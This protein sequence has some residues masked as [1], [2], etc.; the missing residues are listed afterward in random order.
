[1]YICRKLNLMVKNYFFF[2]FVFLGLTTAHSQNL[3]RVKGKIIDVETREVLPF[4]NVLVLGTNIGVISDENGEFVIKDVP[5]GYIKLQASFMG[6][7]TLISDDYLVTIEKT[8]YVLF[9]M[10]VDNEL[11]DEVVI[12]NKLFR[13]SIQ[14]PVSYQSIGIAEIEKNPGGD[15]DVLKVIQSFPGVASNPGFR[16]DIIIRGGSPSEN[17][18]YLDGIE[19]PVINHFQTQGSTGGPVGI[20]NADLIR[21]VDFY[22]SSFSANRGNALSSI[23]EFTMKEGD[24]VKVN[25]RATV[26]T[27]DAGVT[28]DGPMGKKTT[29]MASARQSYLSSL[30]K[31]LKLPFLPTYNDFQ[32]NVKHKFDEKNE[33]SLIGLGAID[34]FKLNKEV[35]DG[36]TDE[37]D[38]KRNNYFLSNIPV[39]NQW[40]YT[41][42]LSYKHYGEMGVQQVVLSRNQWDNVADKYENN[43]G[44]PA[45]LLLNYT[46]RETENKLRYEYFSTLKKNYKL[47]IGVGVEDIQYYNSTYQKFADESGIEVVDFTSKLALFKYGMFA[48]ISKAYFKSKFNVSFG[49]RF[50]GVDYSKEMSNPFKQFSPRFS[51]AYAFAQKWA[52]NASA[53]IYNQ[54]PSYTT[55][56]FRNNNEVLINKE[57]GLEYITANHLVTGF[58]FKPNASAKLTIEAFYKGYDNYPFSVENKISLANL[59]ADFGVVGNEEVTSTSEGRAY[60]FEVF[61]QKKSYTGL[62]GI[63]SY[64]YVISEFK[65]NN[66]QYIPSS[67][68]NR[69]L[70][71]ATGGKKFEKNWELGAKFRLVGGRPYTP[72]DYNASAT[73][74]NY[75]VNNSGILDY[76]E[77]NSLRFDLYHQLDV[78]LDKTWYWKHIALNLYLDIQNIMGSE[79]QEQSFLIPETDADGNYLT[80]PADSSKYLLEEVDNNS[81]T[82]L[83]KIGVIIDF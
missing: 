68:D 57:N 12:Q 74:V 24:P 9:E 23:I 52:V 14:N 4:V 82:I 13:K 25:V 27:S 65:D 19:V 63:L 73:K 37:D 15:R 26:G 47:N 67:W 81:G 70:L 46:S 55:M 72:F 32:L 53:G 79:A 1:M 83:P 35:N 80:D 34:K 41:I 29:F 59:G 33:L 75:N 20:I 3:G 60:G 54:L 7:Q 10:F 16:N 6:Y 77:L 49:V 45:D 56:G 8:P 50:D 22:S 40:N 66:N 17:K 71:T 51:L 62:Y 30:F 5:L 28:V 31:L 11:L 64:T 48:Q 38:L 42:G 2:L 69:N 18:F 43:T 76:G 78:R 39:Q 21:K 58:E 36:L 61:L 44:N